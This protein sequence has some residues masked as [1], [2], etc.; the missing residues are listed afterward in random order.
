MKLFLLSVI[1]FIT[2]A[3]SAKQ[4]SPG[5]TE[6]LSHEYK[7]IDGRVYSRK[8]SDDSAF[9]ELQLPFDIKAIKISGESDDLAMLGD[10]G[11][12]YY[13]REKRRE[14]FN[15]LGTPFKALLKMVPNRDWAFMRCV[16]KTVPYIEDIDGNKRFIGHE[17]ISHIY[18]LTPDGTEIRYADTGLPPDFSSYIETPFR[19]RFIA[20]SIAAS[21][22]T[23]MLI[24]D[25]GHIYTRLADYDSLGNNPMFY[26]YSYKRQSYNHKPKQ[27]NMFAPVS[28]PAEKWRKQ[29]SIKI[30]NEAC[31][32]GRIEIV[33]TGAGNSS[34]ELRVVG[35]DKDG[36]K[37]YYYKEI[38]SDHWL[39]KNADVEFSAEEIIT[40]QPDSEPKLAQS[41]D[42]TFQG[43]LYGFEHPLSVI[44]PDFN[45]HASPFH[46]HIFYN[47]TSYFD[48][49]IHTVDMYTVLTRIDPGLDGTF[50][51]YFATVEIPVEHLDSD[52]DRI[53]DI[54][55]TLFQKINLHS[56][57]LDLAVN[58][59]TFFIQ[60]YDDSCFNIKATLV[61]SER[62]K[63]RLH[64]YGRGYS[65]LAMNRILLLDSQKLN[66]DQLSNEDTA[67][68]S[69]KILLNRK[70]LDEITDANTKY[71]KD[72]R[73]SREL[74]R[75]FGMANT[76]A[77]TFGLH[78]AIKANTDKEAPGLYNISKY[79]T[80]IMANQA[81][82][83]N[84]ARRKSEKEYA[85]A[86]K[87]LIKRINEYT[88]LQKRL[89]KRGGTHP[90]TQS[91]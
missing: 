8:K 28:L 30:E 39:F 57:A 89:R 16:H 68:I 48:L 12:I 80:R 75:T 15:K 65:A 1:I 20:R 88:R 6:T 43:T 73:L 90:K 18:A 13:Y 29:P 4:F 78:H 37:G 87:I 52:N 47:S 21:G 86:S 36:V 85:L 74:L 82:F 17:G 10:D 53:T 11:Y 24:N 54:I 64:P 58:D 51:N 71:I 41:K 3:I 25:Q 72:D 76:I 62:S 79:G 50:K 19:N 66:H 63:L 34:R 56:F 83:T 77:Q 38:Y 61:K 14:W 69:E 7:V 44:I 26:T 9:T 32:T 2:V 59:N 42:L 60:S 55:Q 46:I 35:A 5:T 23:I 45:F 31:I 49:I 40:S 33:T 84:H 91:Q 70:L 27:D 81:S 67:L 22:S